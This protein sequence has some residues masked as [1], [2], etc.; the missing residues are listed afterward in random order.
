MK[1]G[2]RWGK[3]VRLSLFMACLRRHFPLGLACGFVDYGSGEDDYLGD[4]GRCDV[5][6]GSCIA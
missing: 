5:Y 6:A 1:K 3:S 2:G 4:F